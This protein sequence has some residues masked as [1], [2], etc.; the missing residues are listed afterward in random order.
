MVRILNYSASVL[1][2]WITRKATKAVRKP[3]QDRPPLWPTS[4]GGDPAHVRSGAGAT[5]QPSRCIW[6]SGETKIHNQQRSGVKG[7]VS[8]V[9]KPPKVDLVTG[10]YGFCEDFLRLSFRMRLMKDDERWW[11][12]KPLGDSLEPRKHHPTSSQNHPKKHP[13]IIRKSPK[14]RGDGLRPLR[15]LRRDGLCGGSGV[16]GERGGAA[17]DPISFGGKPSLVG[18]NPAGWWFQRFSVIFDFSST[19]LMIRGWLSWFDRAM[20]ASH[21]RFHT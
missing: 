9:G 15:R 8:H 4:G 7:R 19:W 3:S 10:F 11:K 20:P 18:S 5:P 13:K 2:C 21:C 16:E 17:A 14:I 1:S 12:A 6:D